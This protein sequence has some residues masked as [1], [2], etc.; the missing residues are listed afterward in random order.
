M[1]FIGGGIG[2]DGGSEGAGGKFLEWLILIWDIKTNNYF[3][4]KPLYLLY[5]LKHIQ[6]LI[7]TLQGEVL[8]GQ[9]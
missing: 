7:A 3:T 5:I 6:Y 2:W 8:D 4:D 9:N 1:L